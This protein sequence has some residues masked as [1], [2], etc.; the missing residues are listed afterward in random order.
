M[1]NLFYKTANIQ[2][3]LLIMVF[4]AC[5]SKPKEVTEINKIVTHNVEEEKAADLSV[6]ELLSEEYI[7][8]IFPEATDFNPRS[9]EKPYP[10]CSYRF[11]VAGT[12][13]KVGITLVKKY[14]SE[15]NLDKSMTYIKS[16]KEPLE[17]IGI[18]AYYIPKLGQVSVFNDNYLAHIYATVEEVGDKE[19]AIRITKD[20]LEKL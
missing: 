5:E 16:E 6:C 14:A 8:K 18:K 11:L 13:H 1:K 17:G 9:M 19:T 15:K 2:L 4:L 12:N 20:I 10:S 7:L 3:S